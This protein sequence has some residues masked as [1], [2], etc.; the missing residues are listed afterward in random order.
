MI[1]SASSKE[2]QSLQHKIKR[3]TNLL[4]VSLD[5]YLLNLYGNIG[6]EEDFIGIVLSNG[7]IFF[8][9]FPGPSSS[10]HH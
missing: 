8:W 2:K 6:D 5:C 3:G 7:S 10:K 1:C 9:C 4:P